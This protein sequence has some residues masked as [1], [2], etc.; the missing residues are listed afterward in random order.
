MNLRAMLSETCLVC[1]LGVSSAHSLAASDDCASAT[2][3]GNGLFAYDTTGAT[4]DGPNPCASVGFKNVWL[5]YT[6][7]AAANVTVSTCAS[8]F[9]V[10]DDQSVVAVYSGTC[11]DPVNIVCSFTGC[12]IGSSATFSAAAGQSYLV[13]IGGGCENCRSSGVV[14]IVSDAAPP[15][16]DLCTNPTP[17]GDGF[18]AI[19]NIGAGLE[20]SASCADSTADIWYLYTP[21]ATGLA[22][23]MTCGSDF[24]TVLTIYDG[25]SCDAPELACSD[26]DCRQQSF[27]MTSLLGGRQY[28]I[29]IA[30]AA[31]PAR[32][33]F[34]GVG[35]LSARILHPPA[36][37][38]CA[39]A[40][41]VQEGGTPYTNVDAT[42]DGPQDCDTLEKDVWFVYTPA[43]TGLATIRAGGFDTVMSVYQGSCDGPQLGCD[44]DAATAEAMLS[45]GV[46]AGESYY[47]RVGGMDGVEGSGTL[48]VNFTPRPQND[49]CDGAIV[50][51]LGS[52]PF[53]TRGASTDDLF[54][55]C[56]LPTDHIA[57]DVWFVHTAT[58]SGDL[59]I[60]TCGS[61]FDTL[62]AVYA[63]TCPTFGGTEIVCDDDSCG[64]GGPSLVTLHNVSAGQQFYIR[65]GSYDGF[66]GDGVLN[67]IL[68]PNSC[69]LSPEPDSLIEPEPCFSSSNGGC[70]DLSGFTDLPCLPSQTVY[71]TAYVDAGVRDTDWYRVTLAHDGLITWGGRA[72]FAA[73]FSIRSGVCDGDELARA[74]V[75]TPCDPEATASIRLPAGTYYLVVVPTDF[76]SGPLCDDHSHYLARLSMTCDP[77]GA[78]CASSA[79]ELH[80]QSDCAAA[81]GSYKGDGTACQSVSYA[82]APCTGGF[83][84]IDVSGAPGPQCD[85]CQ[86]PVDIGFSFNFYGHAYSSLWINAN[87]FLSFGPV[88]SANLPHPL[89]RNWSPNNVIAPFWTDL[90][91]SFDGKVNYQTLGTAPNRRFIVQWTNVPR[92]FDAQGNTFQ[93]VLFESDGSIEFRYQAVQPTIFD[94]QTG[95]GVEDADGLHATSIDPMQDLSNACFR[96]APSSGPPICA[97][98]PA[99][100]NASGTITVQDIFDF[101]GAWFRGDSRADFN[102]DGHVAVQDIFAFL[103]AWFAGCP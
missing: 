88:G 89:P 40:E 60:S 25:A 90:W 99:D 64:D 97:R 76:F 93:V 8:N 42:T 20:G 13:Q 72:E 45:I 56:L 49:T 61:L 102:H 32:G 11:A 31:A 83:E 17:I 46:A 27:I 66:V 80:T 10:T 86:V 21:S 47:I 87:G 4:D 53:T 98:C 36:N 63:D 14:A 34:Q 18:Y 35:K 44:Q 92:F 23:I 95:M 59:T 84:S 75:R 69:V 7:P 71:G 16:N 55:S 81:G 82:L 29:R 39:N 37:N 26:D 100:F 67:V 9:S 70:A 62:M 52:T 57:Q 43:A 19:S 74:V 58:G 50:V 94:G 91:S 24:N 3:V 5:L 28:L 54:I 15:P 103:A 38:D 79:C 41:P 73:V 33:P 77:I 51:P 85:A 96:L 2:P 68:Q 30:G 48:T 6:A 101:L 78:C 12:G 1:V 65:V 22:E